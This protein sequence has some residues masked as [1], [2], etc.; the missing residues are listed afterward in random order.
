MQTAN[1]KILYDLQL[2]PFASANGKLPHSINLKAFYVLHIYN[3]DY[4]V[5]YKL[6]QTSKEMM[7]KRIAFALLICGIA[8]LSACKKETTAPTPA[9]AATP[10]PTPEVPTGEKSPY[11]ITFKEGT[12]TVTLNDKVGNISITYLNGV[13][14]NTTYK[15]GVGIQVGEYN[16]KADYKDYVLHYGDISIKDE[17][18]VDEFA[19]VFPIGKKLLNY[20]TLVWAPNYYFTCQ[21]NLIRYSS[22]PAANDYVDIVSVKDMGF[23]T[24][25]D[26]SKRVS[27]ITGS[28]AEVT[29]YEIKSGTI[30]KGGKTKV[31][32]DVNFVIKAVSS[33][34][35]M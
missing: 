31:L 22:G 16:T 15:Y 19:T 20:S 18:D 14:N 4:L 24:M 8:S 10:T 21:D 25:W 28:I 29:L 3:Y 35:K 7:N 30:V 12:Q 13:A 17:N 34:A 11:F 9:P 2:K 1:A 32:K 26:G 6:N 23:E 5:K 33:D 27:Q